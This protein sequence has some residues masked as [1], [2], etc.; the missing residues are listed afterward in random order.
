MELIEVYP[1]HCKALFEQSCSVPLKSYL[2]FQMETLE[3]SPHHQDPELLMQ[4]SCEEC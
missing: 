3:P 1:L 2:V 4:C